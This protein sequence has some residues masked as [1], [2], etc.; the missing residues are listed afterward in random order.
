LRIDAPPDK[1][2]PFLVEPE[3]LKNWVGG[4]VES[5]PIHGSRPG[6]G[7]R[8]ID[9][10]RENGREI[11]METEIRRYEEPTRLEVWIKGPGVDVVSDYQLR[12]QDATELTHRQDVRL[13]GFAK[14]LTPFIGGA[15]RRRLVDDLRRLK[16]AVEGQ[17]GPAPDSKKNSGRI[18][19]GAFAMIASSF[20]HRVIIECKNRFSWI[21]GGSTFRPRKPILGGRP[22]G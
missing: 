15:A 12:G 9:V 2:F 3:R 10:F 16:L 13:R 20:G 19:P 17:G 18:D 22:I 7:A 5:R 14:L 4:F 8:S 11:L 1:V 21:V 6:V